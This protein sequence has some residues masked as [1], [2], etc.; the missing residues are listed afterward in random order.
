M[1]ALGRDEQAGS[2]LVELCSASAQ[3]VGSALSVVYDQMPADCA[4][5]QI[6]VFILCVPEHT[7]GVDFALAGTSPVDYGLFKLVMAVPAKHVLLPVDGD[8]VSH[9]A[10]QLRGEAVRWDRKPLSLAA[11]APALRFRLPH[12]FRF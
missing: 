11:H 3:C 2:E 1:T 5:V 10:H 9:V 6:M 12:D 8:A 7:A 4:K